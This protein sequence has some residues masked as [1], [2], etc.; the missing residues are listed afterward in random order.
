MKTS[1]FFW[2][3]K[4]VRVRRGFALIVTLSLMILLT[5][6]SVGLL[7]LSSISLRNSAQG[8]AMQIARNNARLALMLALGDLQKSLGPD[9]RMSARAET[10]AKDPRIGTTVSANTPKAWWLGASHSD[11]TTPVNGEPDEPVK[12]LISGLKDGLLSSE[13]R[14]PVDMIKGGSL[15]LTQ[16]TGGEPIQAGRVAVKNATGIVTGNCAYFVDDEGMKAQLAASHPEVRNDSELNLA[17][18]ILPGTFPI[19]QL[20]NLTGSGTGDIALIQQLGSAKDLELIGV[21]KDVS[22]EKFFAYTTRSKGVLS[23]SR[24]GGLKKDLT[25]AFETPAVFDKVFPKGDPTKFIVISSDKLSQADELRKNGYINWGI[26]RDYY[27]L[28]KHIQNQGG[29]PYLEPSLFANTGFSKP[30]TPTNP[31]FYT[32]SLGPHQMLGT[33]NH[34]GMPYSGSYPSQ[35]PVKGRKFTN[36]QSNP[37]FPLMLEMWEK[38]W[39]G[40]TVKKDNMSGEFGPLLPNQLQTNVQVF[41]SHYNPYNIGIYMMGDGVDRGPRVVKFPQVIMDVRDGNGTIFGKADNKGILQPMTRDEMAAMLPKLS[42]HVGKAMVLEPGHSHVLGFGQNRTKGKSSDNNVYVDTVKD[43]VTKSAFDTRTLRTPAMSGSYSVVTEFAMREAAFGHG[44]DFSTPDTGYDPELCQ[45][46]YSFLAKEAVDPFDATPEKRPGKIFKDSLSRSEM[47]TN[48]ASVV[49]ISLRTTNETY[50]GLRPLVDANIRAQW[51]NPRWDSKLGLPGLAAY[52]YKYSDDTTNPA[53][54]Q[55]ELKPATDGVRGFSYWGGGRQAG[56][57]FDRVILFDVPRRDL[58]SIGQL[59]HAAAGRFSYEP[60]YVVGNSY[61]NPRIPLDDWKESSNDTFSTSARGLEQWKISSNFNLYDA[62]YLVNETLWDSYTFT[63]IPQAADNFGGDDV[64][65]SD[66]PMLLG[67]TKHL[68]NPRYVPYEPQGSNFTMEKLQEAGSATEGS[69]FHNAGHLLVDGSFNVNSTCVDAW[70]AFLTGTLDLPVRKLNEMGAVTGFEKTT[71]VRYPRAATPTGKGMKT[72]SLDENYWTGF[73]ELTE[74]EVKSLATEIVAEIK[75]RGPFLTLGAFV[76]RSLKDDETGKSGALQ[77]AL[78]KSV[79]KDLDSSFQSPADSATVP[80]LPGDA[81]QG[82]GFPGQLLQ[83][84]V[85]QALGPYM[86]VHSD[87]FTIRAYGEAKNGNTVTAKAYCEAVVQRLPDPLRTGTSTGSGLSEL[88]L[89]TSAFGRKFS[90]V[91]F[92]WLHE[93]EV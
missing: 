28:K 89:P 80:T 17:G 16:F 11:G 3:A 61:A 1:V 55:L 30:L 64:K 44:V 33:G 79:N 92:R 2:K 4:T 46:F 14:E 15:D 24:S 58:L 68:P 67:R 32:G 49:Q 38:A 88:V 50:Q 86:T 47:T 81:N 57:G 25:I 90:I 59:Q 12:W 84:D 10:L 45:V 85:L 56:D 13:L 69:F 36:Y 5:V 48:N 41:T 40:T 39:L 22:K 75:E 70:E 52:T 42:A 31:P 6:I 66:I 21:S 43:I 91:S 87:T 78:D 29:V 72:A 53:P 7:S 23:D 62:S 93:A 77:A 82:S 54:K 76:N 18:G 63:T 51:N 73:R 35:A 19:S 26:F 65:A 20:R 27:N 71:G 8:E 74:K 60:T 37:I 34:L 9:A 83:G